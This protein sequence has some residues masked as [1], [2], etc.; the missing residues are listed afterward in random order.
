MKIS[1]CEEYQLIPIREA[2]DRN[3]IPKLIRQV[4][5]LP[6]PKK[7]RYPNLPGL[8]RK[9]TACMKSR[10]LLHG[11]LEGLRKDLPQELIEDMDFCL[12]R[13][14]MLIDAIVEVLT[15]K[16]A[17]QMRWFE[18]PMHLCQMLV[19]ACPREKEDPFMQIPHM[20]PRLLRSIKS[21]KTRIISLEDFYSLSEDTRR[22]L[23]NKELDEA[24]LLD[25]EVFGSMFPFLKCTTDVKV[26]D[27]AEITAGSL[28]TVSVTLTRRKMSDLTKTIDE[29]RLVKKLTSKDGATVEDVE[30][31]KAKIVRQYAQ[32]IV[33]HGMAY[34]VVRD[35]SEPHT[36]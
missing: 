1:W 33:G 36:H 26:A 30:D 25:V 34:A 13:V 18:A 6:D 11:H 14:P 31:E 7:W 4:E 5:D 8:P 17:S 28:V 2:L 24:Q 32:K 35:S 15:Y 23:L 22:S 10:A 3:A 20:N 12:K 21:K 16:Q 19:Q 27:E 29:D 9:T